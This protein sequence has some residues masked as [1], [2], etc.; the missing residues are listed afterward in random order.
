MISIIIVNYNSDNY[1]NKCIESIN[2]ANLDRINI[3]IIIVNNTKYY[4]Q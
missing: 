3:E 2:K 4:Q 1:L